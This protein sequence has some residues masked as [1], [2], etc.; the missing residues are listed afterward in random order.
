[1]ISPQ[2]E[3]PWPLSTCPDFPFVLWSPV[4]GQPV[5]AC[6][7]VSP[8]GTGAWDRGGEGGLHAE[9]YGLCCQWG[10][11]AVPAG[12]A[13]QGLS[14]HHLLCL[15]T[16]QGPSL[17]Q[18]TIAFPSASPTLGKVLRQLAEQISGAS[19]A[20]IEALLCRDVPC[21]ICRLASD[22]PMAGCQPPTAPGVLC[23]LRPRGCMPEE[24]RGWGPGDA[25]WEGAQP[26]SG[27]PRG[28][29]GRRDG[30]AARGL[31]ACR[32]GVHPSCC[33][34]AGWWCIGWG[35]GAQ[36]GSDGQDHPPV[37]A[38][39]AAGEPLS[40]AAAPG[41]EGLDRRMCVGTG[42]ALSRVYGVVKKTQ[43]IGSS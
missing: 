19:C 17:Q 33:S 43:E 20:R 14:H 25:G 7:H 34:R 5:I 10:G 29:S 36:R 23:Q 18:E 40:Q 4:T 2:E 15:S 41:I 9:G 13:Y 35:T 22:S 3:H 27:V 37:H 6:L 24:P 42:M 26:G 1:M 8:H 16:A 12:T 38:L 28:W 11:I 21:W 30:E 32:D 39:G 31:L